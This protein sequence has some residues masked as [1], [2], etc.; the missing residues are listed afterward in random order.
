[1]QQFF[2]KTLL[3]RLKK[4]L[5]KSAVKRDFYRL[6]HFWKSTGNKTR[7]KDNWIEDSW[8]ENKGRNSKS[9]HVNMKGDIVE[10]EVWPG[11][12][13]PEAQRNLGY[14]FASVL[15]HIFR[16]PP[17]SNA[18]CLWEFRVFQGVFRKWLGRHDFLALILQVCC[19]VFNLW[20]WGST[21]EVTD[22]SST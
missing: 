12:V 17:S 5:E 16:Y 2:H 1:M 3:I 20:Q 11:K 7:G 22:H 4:H 8:E 13:F 15:L 9:I 18:D 6:L 21:V 14:S 10:R 19:G